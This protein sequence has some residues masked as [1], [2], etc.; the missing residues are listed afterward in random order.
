[1][2]AKTRKI[3]RKALD[4]R[5]EQFL[6]MSRYVPPSKGWIRAIR[7]SLGMTRAQLAKQIGI[8]QQSL[9]QIENSEIDGTIKLDTLRKAAEALDCHVIYALVPNQPLEDKVSRRARKIAEQRLSRISHTMAL[10][11]QDETSRDRQDRVEAFIDALRDK[12]LWA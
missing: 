5:F 9:S 12:D 3:A 7:E 1:M 6:P 10:E 8:R 2:T 11:A 4:K